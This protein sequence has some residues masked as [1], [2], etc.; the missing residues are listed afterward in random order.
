MG[1]G[2]THSLFGTTNAPPGEDLCS[3]L[4]SPSLRASASDYAADFACSF[5]WDIVMILYQALQM[6]RPAA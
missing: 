6:D 4:L 5:M 2:K 1:T 3:Q